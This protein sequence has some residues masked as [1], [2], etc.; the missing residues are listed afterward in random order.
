[1]KAD[2]YFLKGCVIY[3]EFMGPTTAH[4]KNIQYVV[5]AG[6][7]SIRSGQVWSNILFLDFWKMSED[8]LASLRFQFNWQELL[9]YY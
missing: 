8:F 2:D 5:F 7:L 3:R 1:M 9:V 6:G 4:R